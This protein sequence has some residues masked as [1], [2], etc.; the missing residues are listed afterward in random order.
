MYKV[1][2]TTSGTGSRLKHLTADKNKALV[3]IAGKPVIARIIESYPATV[4]LVVTIGYRGDE[5]ETYLLEA[6]PY[7]D[8]TMVRVDPYEGPGSSLGYSMLQARQELQCPFIFHC[9]DTLVAGSIPSPEEYNWNGGSKGSDRNI[10]NTSS[11]SSFLVA[12]G[13]M[14]AM[15]PKGTETY[16]LFHIGLVG[17]KDYESFWGYLLQVYEAQPADSTL[18]DCSAIRLMMEDGLR[19][20]AVEFKDWYD[21]G[22]LESLKLTMK[23]MK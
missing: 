4:P 7:R 11:Y 23:K 1:L 10:Y 5:V 6:F 2:I 20:R 15:N 19:F 14:S 8:I 3:E 18:N 21:T 9:N 13:Y 22:N 16:D 12:D 17:I